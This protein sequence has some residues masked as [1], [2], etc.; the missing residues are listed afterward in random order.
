M[1][2]LQPHGVVRP[3]LFIHDLPFAWASR[4]VHPVTPKEMGIGIMVATVSLRTKRHY[5]LL[6]YEGRKKASLL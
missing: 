2:C 1:M 4:V 3:M 5:L 6:K